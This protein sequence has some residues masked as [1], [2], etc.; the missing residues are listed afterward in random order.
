MT[1]LQEK[2]TEKFLASLALS[3][4]VTPEMIAALRERMAT[5]KKLKTDDFIAVFNTPPGGSVT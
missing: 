1:D 4:D 5:D 2:I 3:E